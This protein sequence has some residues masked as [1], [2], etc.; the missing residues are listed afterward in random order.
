MAA[1]SNVLARNE[2]L[3]AIKVWDPASGGAGI[4]IGAYSSDSDTAEESV[5]TVVTYST[6]ASGAMDISANMVINISAGVTINHLRIRKTV[7]GASQYFIYKKD[8]TAEVFTYAGTITI[9]SAE[10]S[11]ADPA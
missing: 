10:I 9:T 4:Y 3:E 2:M 6:P 8:I 11:I 5:S 1:S 7:S